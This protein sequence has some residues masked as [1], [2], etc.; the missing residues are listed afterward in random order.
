[1]KYCFAFMLACAACGTTPA[2]MDASLDGGMMIDSGV[3]DASEAG[4]DSGSPCAPNMDFSSDPLNCGACAK[5]CLGGTC[6]SGKCGPVEIGKDRV[7]R[8][9]A[10]ATGVWWAFE[11][12]QV[13]NFTDGAVRGTLITSWTP[14]DL[15]GG[16]GAP[17]DVSID[18]TNIY[19]VTMGVWVNNSFLGG[20]AYKCPKA[21]CNGNPQAIGPSGDGFQ[22]D[23][24]ITNNSTNIYWFHRTNMNVM[25]APK[26]GG[27]AVPV[28]SGIG[29]GLSSTDNSLYFS[30]VSQV[31][32]AV[33]P[34]GMALPIGAASG[35]IVGMTMG[36]NAL[37]FFARNNM[38]TGGVIQMCSLPDCMG[39]PQTIVSSD[40]KN[41]GA[42]AAL[43]D[44]LY[45]SERGGITACKIA[46]CATTKV[47]V[48]PEPMVLTR[49]DAIAVVPG[50]LY[51]E[52]G[53]AHIIRLVL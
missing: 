29:G 11:G 41:L 23:A 25:T 2:G 14:K 8:L 17:M 45:Y 5:S 38:N 9:A 36:A 18:A 39:G 34:M 28:C 15:F 35:T 13:N 27:G 30:G 1:M 47:T 3:S 4:A 26:N 16:M 7:L 46:S 50:V 53:G 48:I 20:T 24:L 10:D 37:F 51:Y 21:G 19:I 32:R 22:F 31:N 12:S 6:A 52:W 33:L 42:M 43:N 49:V 44:T 40:D